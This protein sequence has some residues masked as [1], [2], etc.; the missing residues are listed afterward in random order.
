MP[1]IR[2][3]IP[4]RE[5]VGREITPEKQVE[6]VKVGAAIGL[7]IGFLTLLKRANII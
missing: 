3:K 6:A 4:G 2:L 7:V 1:N 5:L